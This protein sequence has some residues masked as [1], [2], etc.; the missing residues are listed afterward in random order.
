MFN[1]CREGFKTLD[2]KKQDNINKYITSVYPSY[3]FH[4]QIK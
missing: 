4:Y 3:C 2:N 1:K